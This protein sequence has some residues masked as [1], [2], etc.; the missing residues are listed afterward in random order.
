MRAT[1]PTVAPHIIHPHSGPEQT[2]QH[3]SRGSEHAHRD[4]RRQVL[5]SVLLAEDVAAHEAHQVRQGDPDAGQEHAATLVRD[6]VVVPRAHQHRRR[7]RAPGH[8][9]GGK[10]RHVQMGLDVR[11]GGVDHEPGE[12][13]EVGERDERRAPTRQVRREREHHA[14][15]GAGDIGRDRVEVGLD[16]GVA[17]ALH[18]LGQEERYSLDGH[19]GADFQTQED[20]CAGLGKDAQRLPKLEWLVDHGAGVDLHAMEGQGFL[21]VA[22][23]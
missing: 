5:R 12:G 11:D 21:V 22:E 15:H 17:Q 7:R 20:I 18:D 16:G 4:E 8:H 23:E 10:V 1:I 6:V 2:R 13:Q 3:R 19:A 9:E 14:H